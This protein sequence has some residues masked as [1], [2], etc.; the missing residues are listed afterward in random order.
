MKTLNQNYLTF[1][2]NSSGNYTGGGTSGDYHIEPWYP[3]VEKYYPACYSY[4]KDDSKIEKAFKIT[5]ILIDKKKVK[6]E[7]VKDFI[8]LVNSIAEII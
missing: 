3:V 1:T 2:D 8:E 4:W 6:V 7:K 5:Q